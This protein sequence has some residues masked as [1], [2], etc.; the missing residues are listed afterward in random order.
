MKY[1]GEGIAI[2]NGKIFQLTYKSKKGFIYDAINFNKIDEFTF[3]SQEG[4][5]LTTDGTNLIM[6]DGTDIITYLNPTSFKTI[7]TIS[8]TE[9]G[10]VKNNLNELEYIKGYIYANIFTK[11]IIV[12]I[13]PNNG[14]VLGKIDL[15]SFANEAKY[16]Y[17]KSMEMNGIAFDSIADKVFITGKLWPKIYMIR[18]YH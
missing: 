18:I 7:K 6:S 9:N 1:F 15:T 2:L 13:D 5:G 10:Y 4:W 11:N 3:P 14:K 8:V 16:L 12:K 17:P